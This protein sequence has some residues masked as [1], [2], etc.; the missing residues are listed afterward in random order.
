M[1]SMTRRSRR[2]L[3]L[4]TALTAFAASACG[5][6]STPPE[7]EPEIATIR[8][9]VG[10]STPVDINTTANPWVYSGTIT[11]VANQANAVSFRFLGADGQDE[12]IIAAERANI[13]LRLENLAA[14]WGFTATGGSGA[15]FTATITPTGTGSFIPLLRLVNAEHGHDEVNHVINVTVTP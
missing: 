6:D 15:T 9:T 10:T 11:L 8:V 1:F 13:E 2:P 12:P 3:L 14:G 4:C 5:D 7:P